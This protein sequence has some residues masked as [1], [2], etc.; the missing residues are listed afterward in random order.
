M[1]EDT[2]NTPP[3]VV[4]TSGLHNMDDVR[5]YMRQLDISDDVN[6]TIQVKWTKSNL[7][8]R[9]CQYC[10][11]N[12]DKLLKCSSCRVVHYCSKKCQKSDWVVHK[13]YCN[14][15]KEGSK[16]D[17]KKHRELYN[18]V[19]E[20]YTLHH[21]DSII[22]SDDVSH[23]WKVVENIEEEK[24]ILIESSLE[25][26][27]EW[28]ELTKNKDENHKNIYDGGMY[29]IFYCSNGIRISMFLNQ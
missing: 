23:Y 8:I 15:C 10:F 24:Y 21:H 29:R 17:K 3:I 18:T 9:R 19:L 14:S 7:A 28:C 13:M 5:Q 25:D 12:Y 27:Q 16:E 20:Y 1:S 6:P 11:K 26:Y 22:F 2:D 4:Q